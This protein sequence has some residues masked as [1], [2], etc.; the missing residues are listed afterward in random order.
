M[1]RTARLSSP[2]ATLAAFTA[3]LLAA[4]ALTGVPTTGTS[5]PVDLPSLTVTRPSAPQ[6]TAAVADAVRAAV[7]D[8]PAT[9]IVQA[10]PGTV[11]AAREALEAAGGQVVT[12][13][14]I[15]SGFSALVDAASLDAVAE[16]PGV[17]H[18]TLDDSV[19]LA[20][21]GENGSKPSGDTHFV[22]TIGADDAARRRAST[23]AGS[24]SRSSTPASRRCRTSRGASHGRSQPVRSAVRRRRV[25]TRHVH[26]RHRR[27]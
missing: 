3:A 12:D 14:H 25:R 1:D 11:D 10:T 15:I 19:E 24:A 6:P 22:E 5:A 16:V 8:G 13:L 2:R 27:R 21:T 9:V 18:V 20:H 23:A 7:A 26:R 4:V 17:A